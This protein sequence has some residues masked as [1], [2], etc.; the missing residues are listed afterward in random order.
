MYR[1]RSLE[2]KSIFATVLVLLFLVPNTCL[3]KA[4]KEEKEFV[5]RE[6][7][8]A[9]SFISMCADGDAELEKARLRKSA[10]DLVA[11]IEEN[12]ADPYH[13]KL[14]FITSLKDLGETVKTSIV[15]KLSY[16][17]LLQNEQHREFLTKTTFNKD[18]ECPKIKSDY[19]KIIKIIELR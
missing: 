13:L 4:T 8:R 7:P 6:G 1:E 10:D 3:A 19:S 15:L 18:E 5:L 17:L 12:F 9:L 14:L 2:M 11:W 16:A